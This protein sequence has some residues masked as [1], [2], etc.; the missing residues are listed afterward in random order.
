MGLNSNYSNLDKKMTKSQ[1]YDM[2]EDIWLAT[3]KYSLF[4]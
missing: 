2:V 1:E 4:N 3:D